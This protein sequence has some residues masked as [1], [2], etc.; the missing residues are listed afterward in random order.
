MTPTIVERDGKLWAVVGTPGGSTIISAVFQ[1]ILSL[2][3]FGMGMQ[4]AVNAPR[5]HHQWLP[6]VLIMEPDRFSPAMIESL[7]NMGHQVNQQHSRIIGKVDAILVLNDGS[8]EAGA[9]PRGDDA[10]SGF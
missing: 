7:Q 1:T 8:L 4:E 9:D 5:F 6:D 2:R 10:A 3:D